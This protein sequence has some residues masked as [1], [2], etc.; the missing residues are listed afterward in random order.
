L[1][2]NTP[3]STH[4]A[5]VVAPR[6]FIA[7]LVGGLA[8]GILDIVYAFVMVGLRGG[9]PIEVLQS[10]ASG[11]LGPQAFHGGVPTAVLGLALHL[12]ITIVAATI[13]FLA[14]NNSHVMQ[15]HYLIFGALFGVAVYLVMNFV[16]L[17]LSA[18]TFKLSYPPLVLIRGFVSHA[19]LVGIPIAWCLDRFVF[20]RRNATI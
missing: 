3:A 14:A 19:L 15:R 6:P 18:V 8:A 5:G 20:R 10:I 17:P 1:I 2:S 11:L 13:Y 9:T 16:V 4:D 12:F 7:I